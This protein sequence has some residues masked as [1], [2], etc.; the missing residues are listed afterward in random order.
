VALQNESRPVH[1]LTA[2]FLDSEYRD[3]RDRQMKE[4]EIEDDL[5]N[6]APVRYVHSFI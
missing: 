5:L 2:L 6:K 4:L 3:V 1:E